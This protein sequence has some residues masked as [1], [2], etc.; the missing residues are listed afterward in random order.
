MTEPEITRLRCLLMVPP[1]RL[2]AK[3][4]L[5]LRTYSFHDPDVARVPTLPMQ[6]ISSGQIVDSG[7]EVI[8]YS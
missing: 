1:S 6:H 4:L 5:L 8:L 2:L 7:N 3:V